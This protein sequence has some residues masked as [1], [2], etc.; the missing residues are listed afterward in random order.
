MIAC[1]SSELNSLLSLFNLEDDSISL[2]LT[3]IPSQ[4]SDF[5]A[6]GL[7]KP[8]QTYCISGLE[9]NLDFESCSMLIQYE[10]DV[11]R[12]DRLEN[13]KGTTVDHAFGRTIFIENF[14]LEQAFKV[15][16]LGKFGA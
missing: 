13:F 10:K 7:I 16:K 2:I 12:K 6:K 9:E 14:V 5:E 1:E 8:K 4:K 15:G 11:T 3:N